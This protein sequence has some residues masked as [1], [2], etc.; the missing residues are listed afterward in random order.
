M[1][2]NLVFLSCH[3]LLDTLLTF[4]HESNPRC[5]KSDVVVFWIERLFLFLF[6]GPYKLHLRVCFH[7]IIPRILCL[8][9]ISWED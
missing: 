3:S 2:Y 1:L 8:P 4:T 5:K 7:E 6:T 9:S